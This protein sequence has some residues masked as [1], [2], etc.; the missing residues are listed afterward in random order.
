M[1]QATEQR[2]TKSGSGS[3]PPTAIETT[4]Y[5]LIE[6]AREAVEPWEE[7]MVPFI[8]DRILSRQKSISVGEG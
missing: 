5:E 3:F 4:L 6:A 2:S 8:V 1:I 7:E